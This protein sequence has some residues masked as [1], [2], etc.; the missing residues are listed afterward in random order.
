AAGKSNI[1]L[2]GV[3]GL[4][5]TTIQSGIWCSADSGV[6]WSRVLPTSASASDPGTDVAF[7]SDGTAWVALGNPFGDATNNGIYKSS[8]VV[9]SCS[10]TFTAQILPAGTPASKLGRITLDRKSTRLNSS[11]VEISYAVFCLKKK[12]KQENTDK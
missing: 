9:S 4:A 12:N 8:A 2:A 10:I 7:A 1:L 3:R 6:T 5:G 11:H